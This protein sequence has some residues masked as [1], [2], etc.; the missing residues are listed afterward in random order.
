M[1]IS[2]LNKKD[3][4]FL[5]ELYKKKKLTRKAQTSYNTNISYYFGTWALRDWGL[6]QSNGVDSRRQKV[7]ILTPKGVKVAK[8]LLALKEALNV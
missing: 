6:I 1:E 7:Y 4:N 2:D 3:I 8:L 5:I